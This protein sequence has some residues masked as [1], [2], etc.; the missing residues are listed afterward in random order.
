MNKKFQANAS[1]CLILGA[2]YGVYAIILSFATNFLE[3]KGVSTPSISVILGIATGDSCILSI[4]VAEAVSRIRKLTMYLVTLIMTLLMLVGL[5]AMLIDHNI[6]AI[7]GIGLVCVL[8]Q[9]MPALCNSLGMDAIAKGAPASFSIARGA[10]SLFYAM[11]AFMIGTLVSNLGIKMIPLVS[12]GFGIFL[13]VGI[14]WFHFCAEKGLQEQVITEKKVAAKGNFMGKNPRFSVFLVGATFLCISHFLVCNFIQ[15]IV[16][17]VQLGTTEQGIATGITA[18]VELPIM[19][20]FALL[21]RKFRCHQM[22]KFAAVAFLLKTLGLYF[23]T[24]AMGVYLAQA[25]QC[26]GYGLYAVAS[27]TYAG[28]VVSKDD[29][30]RAQTYLATTISLGNLVA[31]ATG[32]FLVEYLQVGGLLFD[33]ACYMAELAARTSTIAGVLWHQ[34]ESDCGEERYPLYEGKLTIILNAFRQRLNLYDVPFLL[35]GLGDFLKDCQRKKEFQNYRYVNEAL[36]KVEETTN[37]TM[38][39]FTQGMNLP[40]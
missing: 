12:A 5:G 14:L 31:M 9:M 29:A 36:K 38:G 11:A 32:G 21:S 30:V 1:Y 13:V 3:S 18:F 28:Q 25:T 26:I 27:V 34:G 10:G 23:A 6:I 2:M 40:F 15:Y 35:G 22:L 17:A 37:A 24:N 39:K 33:H 4:G 16:E 8:L 19:F 20:G 7:G